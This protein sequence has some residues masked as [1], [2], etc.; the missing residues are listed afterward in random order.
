MTGLKILI[1]LSD[2]RKL[3]AA[4]HL[5]RASCKKGVFGGCGGRTLIKVEVG[6]GDPG[7]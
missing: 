1:G 4:T 5:W 7:G 2:L 6:G 3:S